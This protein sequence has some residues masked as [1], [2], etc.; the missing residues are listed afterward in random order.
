MTQTQKWYWLTLALIALLLF[1]LLAPVLT[2]FMAA[3][4]L[5]Y[6]GDPLADRLERKLPR[7][8]AVVIVFAFISLL[9][10]LLLVVLVPLVQ[11]QI[12]QFV[13]K[14][15]TYI[16][17]IQGQ[18]LPWLAQSLGLP[19]FELNLAGL[20]QAIRDNWS[21]AGGM[22]ANLL[23]TVSKS[24]MAMLA[25]LANIV[26]IPVLTFYLLRDWDVLVAH[27][28]DLLPRSV[29]PVVR[30]LALESDAV[31]GAFLRGQLLVM[32]ALGAI[33]SIGLWLVGLDF[34]LLIGLLAG[35]VSFVPYLGFL[36]GI[37]VAGVA[38][39]LQF[40]DAFYLLPVLLVFGVGQIIES[41][42]LTPLLVGDR[43]GLHPVAV[44]FAVMTGGQLFGFFGVLLALP[45]AAVIMVL[46]RYLH[47]RYKDS[48]LYR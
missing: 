31:L 8:L 5:A 2:P 4:I 22:A 25:G 39:L 40:Q 44:I 26:L 19:A 37:V 17:R 36:V 47:Q 13:G 21:S 11:Q 32:I 46:L 3:A 10:I 28:H 30:R 34:S 9:A 12:G 38:A 42:V 41:V 48:E 35:L 45:S 33:Y 1:Y 14:L 18:F 27:V 15:P 24:G 7:T 20:K 29:E 43:I 16:D 6:M 23:A